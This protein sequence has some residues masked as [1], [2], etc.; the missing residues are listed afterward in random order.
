MLGALLDLRAGLVAAIDQV[1][2]AARLSDR[3][4]ELAVAQNEAAVCGGSGIMP[5]H[6]P[7]WALQRAV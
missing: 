4:A 3:E 1:K 5:V 7:L 6:L 2:Q